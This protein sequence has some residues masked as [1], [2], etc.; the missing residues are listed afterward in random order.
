MVMSMIVDAHCH[1]D[2]CKEGSY[3][4]S[5]ILPITHGH[6]HHANIKSVTLG[7]AKNLPYVIGIAPQSAQKEGISKLDE[8]VSYIKAQK[9]VAIGE[10]G[11]DN[12]WATEQ[13]HK[14]LQM[15]AF[16]AMVDL[17]IDMELPVVIHAREST[18]EVVDY[19]ESVKFPHGV[20]L[21]FFSGNLEDAKRTVRLGGVI[22][23]PCV[24]SSQR[25]T[26]IKELG[27]DS[28]VVETDA[29]AVG[30]SPQDVMRSITYVSG[31][32][33]CSFDSAAEK[34]AENAC[35]FFNIKV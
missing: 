5:Q 18:T 25:K 30:R 11:L 27:I 26:V 12:H 34:T 8:W 16:K 21:H 19:L 6:S 15:Y 29:P 28:I 2:M 20:M 33:G 31:I 7:T 32:L 1:L 13:K 23:I 4:E 24:G 10:I 22:S 17:A 14:A 35:R 9:P 3:D